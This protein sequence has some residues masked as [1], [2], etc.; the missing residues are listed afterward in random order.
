MEQE[1]PARHSTLQEHSGFAVLGIFCSYG[2]RAVSDLLSILVDP[3]GA[4]FLSVVGFMCLSVWVWFKIGY[5]CVLVCSCLSRCLPIL[6][7]FCK[8]QATNSY[9]VDR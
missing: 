4:S 6:I 9:F 8:F 3:V 2:W 7:R 5:S 1:G